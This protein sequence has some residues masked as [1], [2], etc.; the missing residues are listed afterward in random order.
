MAWPVRRSRG[1]GL[2]ALLI[3]V[4]VGMAPTSSVVAAQESSSL[5]V[6]ITYEATS[7]NPFA[8]FDGWY[9]VSLTYDQLVGE[10]DASPQYAESWT[11]SPDGLTWTFKTRSGMTWSDGQPA[12]ARDA[13]FTYNYLLGSVGLPD[14]L[15]AGWNNTSKVKDDL[16]SATA[17][18]DQTLV[19]NLKRPSQWPL[20]SAVF[21]VPEHVWKDVSYADALATFPN[22]PP[23]VGT[24]PYIAT[25][26][27]PGKYL[28]MVANDQYRGGRPAVDE[29]IFQKFGADDAVAAALKAGEIDFALGV[30]TSQ[31]DS[32]DSPDIK[33]I[34][35]VSGERIEL[36]FN[37]AP[38][39]RA[40]STALQ[41]PA[42]RDALG[43][44]LDKPVLVDK[45]RHGQATV[46]VSLPVPELPTYFSP[47][48]DI[49]R[50]FSLD[51]A[52]QKLDAAGY[53][54]SNGDGRREDRDGKELDL[55]LYVPGGGRN[56]A[57]IASSAQFIADWFGQVG[58]GLSVTSIEEAA[59]QSLYAA[60][61]DGGGDWDISIYYWWPN[62]HPTFSFR[63]ALTNQIGSQNFAGWS[64]AEFDAL[65]AD[66]SAQTSPEAAVPIV[67]QMTRLVYQEAPYHVLYYANQNQAYRTDRFEGW[68]RRPSEESPLA[69]SYYGQETWVLLAPIGAVSSASPGATGEPSVEASASAGPAASGDGTTP[70]ST[71]G[72]PI[73]L[74]AVVAAGVLV[75]GFLVL[76]SRRS[77]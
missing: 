40:T 77:S 50:P 53:V 43:Y 4:L 10:L 8:D 46:G 41:D 75:L 25:E 54:D 70:A 5:R 17:P 74:V 73:A 67:D 55:R 72:V 36:I 15:V 51:T 64:S 32:L 68:T 47:L 49:A 44:A 66:L 56:S 31:L 24:G 20:I 69:N 57:D 18:D 1:P 28:K 9:P 26:F 23:I 35:A 29:I 33:V 27:E 11:T 2:V 7:L 59:L 14:E 3:V 30:P 63:Q 19:L 52:K 60:P 76:R 42:F 37:T 16:S 71:G 58:I 21:I 13:A 62:S 48:T 6:G 45:V 22:D 61:S 38:G 39:A 12:T 65:Y 34:S